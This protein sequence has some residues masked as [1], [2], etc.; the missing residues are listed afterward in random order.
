VLT[1]LYRNYKAVASQTSY[2]YFSLA[3]QET[4]FGPLMTMLVRPLAEVLAHTQA[5]DGVHSTGPNYYLSAEDEARLAPPDAANLD[6]IDFFL[7]RFG[8]IVDELRELADPAN[9][10]APANDDAALAAVAR[11]AGDVS[12]LRRQLH[13]VYES[14]TAI[15]NNMRR[16]YQIGQLPQFTVVPPS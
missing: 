3:L 7:G 11:S 8:H 2:P 9:P 14:A 1:S 13:F 16:I 4:A 5:G 12:F 10:A 15:Q 6:D